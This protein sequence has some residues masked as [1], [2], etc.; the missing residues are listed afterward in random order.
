M[1][2]ENWRMKN[3]KRKRWICVFWQMES[4]HRKNDISLTRYDIR[5]RRMIYCSF[6]AIWYKNLPCGQNL[7]IRYAHNDI[8]SFI[9]RRHISSLK[10]RYHTEGISPVPTGTD[11]IEKSTRICVLFSWLGRRDSNPRI[12]QSKCCVLPL[13]DSS[14]FGSIQQ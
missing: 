13:D 8:R 7:V 1:N 9:C 2:T 3:T 4:I 10:E 12:Q 11:I 6:V 5:L 14:K